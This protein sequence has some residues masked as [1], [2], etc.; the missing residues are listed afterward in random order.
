[1]MKVESTFQKGT[2]IT[3]LKSSNICNTDAPI[4]NNGRGSTFSP[5]DLLASSLASCMIT[6]M[7]ITAD[8]NG[9]KFTECWAEIEK[10]MESHPRRIGEIKINMYFPKNLYSE[11]QKELLQ[12]AALNCPVA[13]SLNSDLKQTVNFIFKS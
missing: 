5:T 10:V 12:R 4:D 6:I 2:Q 11:K 9:F 3:H 8:K 13:R 7:D 1:M